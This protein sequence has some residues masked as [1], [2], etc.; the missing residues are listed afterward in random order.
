MKTLKPGKQSLKNS[1]SVSYTH[2]DVYKRQGIGSFISLD[3]VY[4]MNFTKYD[5]IHTIA[6]N[7]NSYFSHF[8]I[9]S[10]TQW[11]SRESPLYTI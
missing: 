7:N 6:L 5:G 3:N 10:I 2:L 8:L 11:L 9:P 1:F 4:N